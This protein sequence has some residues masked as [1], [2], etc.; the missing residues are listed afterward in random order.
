MA[1]AQIGKK[2]N[3]A[4]FGSSMVVDPWGTV[5]ARSKQEPWVTIAEIDLDF[6]DKIRS[7]IPSLR[8]RRRDVYDLRHLEAR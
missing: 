3:F 1:P 2:P 8:N 7:Q 6:L 5:I 4:A